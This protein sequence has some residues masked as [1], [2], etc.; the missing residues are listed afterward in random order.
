MNYSTRFLSHHYR[1]AVEC[2]ALED[3]LLGLGY[4]G[5][6]L[7]LLLFGPPIDLG[8]VIPATASHH[9][10]GGGSSSSGSGCTG[11][12]CRSGGPFLGLIIA[13]AEGSIPGQLLLRLRLGLSLRL[14]LVLGLSV[15]LV[16][17]VEGVRA[18]VLALPGGIGTHRN[19]AG[20]SSQLL[21][22]HDLRLLD[23]LVHIDATVAQTLQ[24]GLGLGL[25]RFGASDLV[26]EL[27]DL[28]VQIGPVGI[29]WIGALTGIPQR[30]A[31]GQL[32]G[33][34]PYGGVLLHHPAGQVLGLL[35]QSLGSG[36]VLSGHLAD[37]IVVTSLEVVLDV[38]LEN[39]IEEVAALQVVFPGQLLGL[40]SDLSKAVLRGRAGQQ[41]CA[42]EK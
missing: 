27:L 16:A 41:L 10:G 21:H 32:L 6:V 1:I 4:N 31:Q 24:T 38:L 33:I 2:S 5:L 9:G 40:I 25:L 15:L 14:G 30:L 28:G 7:V 29:V 42:S 18:G 22:A 11:G 34:L 36:L 35:G 13:V 3:G 12:C 8:W 37:R 23:P 20:R 17:V 26:S 19:G 39:R